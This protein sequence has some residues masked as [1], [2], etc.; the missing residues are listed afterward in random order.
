[1]VDSGELLVPGSVQTE[2]GGEGVNPGLDNG[3][4]GAHILI[5]PF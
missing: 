1:M 2:D 4:I 3:P 5:L